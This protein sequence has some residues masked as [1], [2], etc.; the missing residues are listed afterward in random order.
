MAGEG[1][2]AE[3][4]PCIRCDR[5]IDAYAR[6]CVYC[7]WEQAVPPVET[8]AAPLAHPYVPPADNRLRNRII[9]AV[10]FATL[11][12]LAFIL[13]S[14]VHSSGDGKPAAQNAQRS[15]AS[16]VEPAPLSTVTL[17][18]IEGNDSVQPETPVTTVPAPPPAAGNV[19]L[20]GERADATA[21]PS[22]TYTAAANRA[23]AERNK[24]T[25][26][27]I[28]DPRSIAGSIDSTPTR[29]SSPRP[30]PSDVAAAPLT[31]PIPLYQPMPSM[32]V[33]R[34]TSARLL[35]TIDADGRVQDINVAQ[36]IPGEMP[37]LIASVQN[38]RYKPA[39]LNGQPVTSRFAVDINVHP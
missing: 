39:T 9:G 8:P 6:S 23:K 18:P 1:C 12:I 37:R 16:P 15:P 13:G 31:Q 4:R 25:A 34:P 10:A 19:D 24:K 5:P 3:H 35:L 17:V 21:L 36:S 14:L 29:T 20:N 26:S 22:E 32:S 38:W 28:I 11:V 30:Q 33:D 7:G 2:M 27:S